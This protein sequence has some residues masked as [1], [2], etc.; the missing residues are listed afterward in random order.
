MYPALVQVEEEAECWRRKGSPGALVLLS[1]NHGAGKNHSA[2][3]SCQNRR[4][5]LL[6]WKIVK[7][8]WLL[9]IFH[10]SIMKIFE[11]GQKQ[12]K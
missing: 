6:A 7:E 11:H 4:I 9:I 5:L 12:R 8:F 3:L 2:H 10:S 1:P